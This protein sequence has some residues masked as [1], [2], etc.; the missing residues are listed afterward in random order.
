MT[1]NSTLVLIECWCRDS[2]GVTKTLSFASQ[3]SPSCGVPHLYSPLWSKALPHDSKMASKESFFHTS[4][5][6]KPRSSLW[7]AWWE[8]YVHSHLCIQRD[9][10][11]SWT[12]GHQNSSFDIESNINGRQVLKHLLAVISQKKFELLFYRKCGRRLLYDQNH[13]YRQVKQIGGMVG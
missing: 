1:E 3:G 6:M 11:S 2:C 7:L 4:V 5:E 8:S 9:G 13:R 12:Y 10:M